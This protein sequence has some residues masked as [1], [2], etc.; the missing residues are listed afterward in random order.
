MPR[1]CRILSLAIALASAQYLSAQQQLGN[2]IGEIRVDRGDF[3]AHPVYVQLQLRFATINSVYAD[4][5]GR[6]G[7][8]FLDA[9]VYHVLIKEDGFQPVDEQVVVD[10]V[11]APTAILQITLR[12]RTED[13]PNALQQRLAGSNPYLIDLGEYRRNFPK[14]VLKEFD[15]GLHADQEGKRDEAIRHYQKALIRAPDFYPA[16]NNLGSDY[17]TESNLVGARKEFEEAVRL[18]QSDAAGYFN[19]GNVCMLSGQFDEAQQFLNEGFRREPDSALGQ[20]LLGS[21]DMRTG[22]YPEAESALKRAIQTN[23]V[24]IQARLQLINLLVKLGRNDEAKMQLHDF[25]SAFP[26]NAYTPKA[27]QLLARLGDGGQQHNQR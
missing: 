10:P 20:F 12:P 27:K 3:P 9:N 16:H 23:P 4:N 7:F 22:N 24:M 18:N 15:R 14:N 2:I 11:S 21:L 5:Q 6:F 1:G 19:L 13:K 26:D 17:L 8:Y 25:V